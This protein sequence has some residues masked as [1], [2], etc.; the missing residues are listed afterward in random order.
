MKR[1]FVDVFLKY[2][3]T[4]FQQQRYLYNAEYESKAAQHTGAT[5][6]KQLAIR[7]IVDID[8]FAL[9]SALRLTPKQ[10]D[11]ACAKSLSTFSSK[12][13]RRYNLHFDKGYLSLD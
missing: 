12:C 2:L 11:I 5:C 4:L 7:D 3:T 1:V 8:L 13:C 10:R 6:N 9:E